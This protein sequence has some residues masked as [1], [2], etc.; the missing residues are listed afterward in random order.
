M[1][2]ITFLFFLQRRGT[3]KAA[4]PTG[5]TAPLKTMVYF[6]RFFLRSKPYCPQFISF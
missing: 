5:M 3:K 1:Q 6:T 2:N 4:I